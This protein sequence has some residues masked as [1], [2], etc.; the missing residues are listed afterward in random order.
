M[1]WI[2][3]KVQHIL[4]TGLTPSEK[5]MLIM[6]QALT[7]H[8][9]RIP[10][11]KEIIAL[12]GLSNKAYKKL[13]ESLYNIDV[14][15]SEVL[16]KVI[17][18]VSDVAHKRSLSKE[19]QRKLRSKSKDVTRDV[20]VTSH[21]LPIRAEKIRE[22]NIIKEKEEASLEEKQDLSSSLASSQDN[23]LKKNLKEI[24]MPQ[25]DFD[26]VLDQIIE[27]RH[28]K[29]PI[30]NKVSFR[31]M[32]ISAFLKNNNELQVWYAQ[33]K[34]ADK[35]VQKKKKEQLAQDELLDK[36]RR[37]EAVIDRERVENERLMDSFNKFSSQQRQA[38]LKQAE[39][40]IKKVNPLITKLDPSSPFIQSFICQI[41]REKE[42]EKEKEGVYAS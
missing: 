41:V 17:E 10:T 5:G 32:L 21:K 3:V 7:A 42:K 37:K 11:E 20:T 25:N 29:K 22:D 18:D 33:L 35:L 30:E 39:S 9:E 40:D 16:R 27:L 34:E 13:S 8:L 28:K 14:D 6:I 15:L 23:I 24:N 26:S 38:I 19:R 4:F 2:K 31:A 12:P 1:D 36:E